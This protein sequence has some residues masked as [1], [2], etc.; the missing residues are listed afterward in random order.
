[1]TGRR[2]FGSSSF[3][4]SR[5]G[6]DGE[7]ILCFFLL[8]TSTLQLPAMGQH[9]A[10]IDTYAWPVLVPFKEK[11]NCISFYS[12]SFIRFS[13]VVGQNSAAR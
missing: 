2:W 10:S 9:L 5:K 1:M 11:K 3:F 6:G 7:L 4:Y 13:K 12:V 8:A